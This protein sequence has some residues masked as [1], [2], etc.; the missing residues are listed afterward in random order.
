MSQHPEG[1]GATA[2]DPLRRVNRL[3]AKVM[4]EAA[5]AVYE[6]TPVADVE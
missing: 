1:R 3:L 6:G 2:T 4:G 5:R